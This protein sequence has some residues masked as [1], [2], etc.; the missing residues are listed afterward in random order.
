VA[1][2]AERVLSHAPNGDKVTA[3][4]FERRHR[5]LQGLL[6]LHPPAL[7]ALGLAGG[8]ALVAIAMEAVVVP[9]AL[10]ALSIAVS[11]RRHRSLA[12]TAG[13]LWCSLVA[14]QF[15]DGAT[16]AHF[17]T[18]VVLALLGLYQ[19]WLPDAWAVGFTLLG[20][21][22]GA[23][24]GATMFASS[25]AQRHPWGWAGLEAAAVLAAATAQL[26]VCA[27]TEDEQE[28]AADLAAKLT[29]AQDDNDRRRAVGDLLVS[30][31]RRNQSLL[32]RQLELIDDLEN[33]EQDP[34]G[35]AG[36]FRIDHF[37][38]RM[39]RNAENLLVLSGSDPGR[40]WNEPLP[41][42]EVMRGAVAEVEDYTRVDLVVADDP[43]IAGRAVSDLA[44]LLAEL[45][46]NGATFS[47]PQTRVTVAGRLVREGYRIVVEDHGVGVNG[48]A[49]AA[50]NAVLARPPEVDVDLSRML[51]LNVVSRLAARHGFRVALQANASGGTSAVVTIPPGGLHDPRAA[52]RPDPAGGASAPARPASP[53]TRPGAPAEAPGVARTSSG[54]PVPPPPPPNTVERRA[55]PSAPTPGH[56]TASPPKAPALALLSLPDEPVDTT[57]GPSP[58]ATRQNGSTA[59]SGAAAPPPE[60]EAPPGPA[61]GPVGDAERRFFGTDP[62]AAVPTGPRSAPPPPATPDGLAHRT[63]QSHLA[64]GMRLPQ[65]P[66]QPP[67]R[68]PDD[69]DLVRSR[70][71]SYQRGLRAGRSSAADVDASSAGEDER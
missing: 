40:R 21:G 39:R 51:G 52:R 65:P 44:H 9:A 7:A 69:P 18:F 11:G 4:A 10:L 20:L 27:A 16:V 33:R 22:L 6:A 24:V 19:D 2:L 32:E 17:H 46:E 64:P 53:A 62:R 49:L 38:T 25:S 70:L 45:I 8:A 37:A 26:L 63:P 67:G 61:G 55:A 58:T 34:D 54:I 12:V 48:S 35:L 60:A 1:T 59:R 28:R 31:A 57:L 3:A 5:V 13:L 66:P 56:P 36:L 42:S 68:R 15:S 30:L 14:V 47:P 50:H 23:S 41:A 43:A 29:R 71:S